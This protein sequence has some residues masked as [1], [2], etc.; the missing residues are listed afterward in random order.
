MFEKGK[1]V[2][3]LE[4]RVL[5]INDLINEVTNHFKK[6]GIECRTIEAGAIPVVEVNGKKYSVMQRS[7]LGAIAGVQQAMLIPCK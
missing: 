3:D 4:N 6:Q 1:I 7:V 5:N 2:F